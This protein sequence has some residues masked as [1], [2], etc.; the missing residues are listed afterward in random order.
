MTSTEPEFNKCLPCQDNLVITNLALSRPRYSVALWS[1]CSLTT[2]LIPRHDPPS[3]IT[4]FMDINPNP[5]SSVQDSLNPSHLVETHLQVTSQCGQSLS[6]S[7]RKLLH[8]VHVTK[9]SMSR[10]TYQILKS[11]Q[12]F[13]YR[14][15]G[16][17]NKK[18][19]ARVL[20]QSCFDSYANVHAILQVPKEIS[21]HCSKAHFEIDSNRV[22]Q[23]SQTAHHVPKLMVSNVMSLVPK[24]DEVQEFLTSFWLSLQK[25]G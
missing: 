11:L 1:K 14:G 13:H 23:Q 6:Y 25:P 16:T 8:L 7:R 3:D 20:D 19:Q 24:I 18:K 15:K 2:L 9:R 10:S 5:L 22:E 4:I 17:G 21:P 12:I